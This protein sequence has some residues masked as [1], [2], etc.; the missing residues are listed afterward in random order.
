MAEIEAR[1]GRSALAEE[2]EKNQFDVLD[3]ERVVFSKAEQG[4][5]PEPDEIIG[6]LGSE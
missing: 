2:G 6:A 4:R 3:G 5:F 1:T